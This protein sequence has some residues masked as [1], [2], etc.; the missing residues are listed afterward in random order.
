[1]PKINTDTVA[2][3]VAVFVLGTIVVEI[4][5]ANGYWPNTSGS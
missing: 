3:G 2:T 1:M 5:K 4:M